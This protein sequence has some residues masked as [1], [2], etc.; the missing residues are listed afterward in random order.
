[1]LQWTWGCRYPFEMISFPLDVYLEMDFLDHMV[2]LL[3][4]FWGTSI[5]FSIVTLPIYILTVHKD[6]LTP[7]CCQHL[8]SL[9]F[10]MIAILT[11]VRTYLIV[12][13]ICFFLMISD[14]EHF[15]MYL[16]VIWL[17]YL[18]GCLFRSFAH[19]K[20]D[21]YYYYYPVELYEFLTVFEH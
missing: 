10:L 20:L 15:F 6:S 7:H 14:I 5:M 2:L 4:I 21:Y 18:E 13:L 19:F 16:L 8:L 9:V 12:V 11:G 1:M 17:S 3:L